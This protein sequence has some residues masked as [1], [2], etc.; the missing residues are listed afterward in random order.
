MADQNERIN[1]L[2]GGAPLPQAA[3]DTIARR[4]LGPGIADRYGDAIGTRETTLADVARD[5]ALGWTSGDPGKADQLKMQVVQSY[6][7]ELRRADDQRMQQ[8]EAARE[9]MRGVFSL[10]QQAKD[11]PKELRKDFFKEGLEKNGFEASSP[12]FLKMVSDFEK[13]PDAYE[14]FNDPDM[15]RLADD[16]PFAAVEQLTQMTQDPQAATAT[17][18]TFL[19]MKRYKAE[20]GRIMS[21]IAKNNRSTGGIRQVDS[22]AAKAR[23]N[24]LRGAIDKRKY[25]EDGQPAGMVTAQ[26]ALAQADIAWPQFAKPKP[27]LSGLAQSTPVAGSPA[28]AGAL[29]IAGAAPVEAAP[30]PAAAPTGLAQQPAAGQIKIKRITQVPKAQ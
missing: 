15:Q 9:Q 25:D 4:L 18:K 11:V 20:T 16:D 13:Y 12:F 24:Y 6:N 10:F 22:A 23:E 2:S 26:E 19:E 5:F 17:V 14:A 1:A 29:D 21:Q 30:A 3:T 27:Q 28:S 8:E 7:E